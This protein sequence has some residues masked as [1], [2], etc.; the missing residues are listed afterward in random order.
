MAERLPK[1]YT[2][3][4]CAALDT[5]A[6]HIARDGISQTS[7]AAIT[8]IA[9]DEGIDEESPPVALLERLGL[10]IHLDEISI[11]CVD[12]THFS[13]QRSLPHRPVYVRPDYQTKRSRF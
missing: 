9:L 3:H 7:P 1:E 12:D 4:W 2:G 8:L 10:S 13:R 5:G 6:V 11:R